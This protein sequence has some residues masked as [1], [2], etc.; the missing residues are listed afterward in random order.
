LNRS[1]LQ[2]LRLLK[3]IIGTVCTPNLTCF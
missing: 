3:M 2:I 1:V